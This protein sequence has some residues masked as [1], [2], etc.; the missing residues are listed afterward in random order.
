MLLANLAAR[1]STQ[2]KTN[3]Q[4][5]KIGCDQS[6]GKNILL[7]VPGMYTDS[8]K[9]NHQTAWKTPRQTIKLEIT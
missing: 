5:S 4:D 9:E 2:S 6:I 1:R 3:A 8:K 7:T